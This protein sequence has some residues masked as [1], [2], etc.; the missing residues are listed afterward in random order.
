MQDAAEHN[1]V[2][3]FCNGTLRGFWREDGD[4]ESAGKYY[5]KQTPP[6]YAILDLFEDGTMINEYISHRV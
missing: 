4:K 5:Y 3:Y 2:H 6:G 1:G